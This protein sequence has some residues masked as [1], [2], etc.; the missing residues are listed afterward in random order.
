MKYD[1]DTPVLVAVLNN[2]ADWQRIRAE[3]WYRIPLSRAPSQMAAEVI[4]WYQTKAF[5]ADGLC[6]RWYASII[7]CT[8]VTRRELL[9]QE[10]DHPRADERYWRLE[11]GPLNALP[12]PIRAATFRRVT[13]IPTR[14]ARLLTA[15]D[16][17]ELWLGDA[18]VEDL[19]QAL[20]AQ[21]FNIARR[22][23]RDDESH[24][25]ML[26][27]PATLELR[28][29]PLLSEVAVQWAGGELRFEYAAIIWRTA[30]C[31][32]QICSHALPI[33]S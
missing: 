1:P 17:R 12:H 30:T 2:A 8:I 19:C 22:S 29:V 21:G 33:S 4:A 7:R 15:N 5:G 26:E 32:R 25:L 14:W 23:I 28:V 31:V 27:H 13:F 11:L 3:H 10:A 20:Q 6:V 18:A 24:Y 16:V 9:P